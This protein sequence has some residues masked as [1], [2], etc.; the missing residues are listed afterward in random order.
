M[1]VR[2]NISA[3]EVSGADTLVTPEA[4]A[5]V[6]MLH[7][8]FD[9][10]R[11]ELLAEREARQARFD[12]GERPAFLDATRALREADWT[13]APIPDDLLDRRVEIT[14][15]PTRKMV[16]NAL[17]SGATHFMADFEDSTAPTWAN[18]VEGQL[19]LREAV[20][21]TLT[22]DDPARGKHYALA[23]ERAVLLVRPR[24]WH[25]DEAHATVDGAPVS[26]S[27]FDFGLYVFHNLAALR[28]RGTSAYFYL[29]KLEHHEE[30][31]LWD[32]VFAC[33]EEALAVPIGTL[34][35]TVLVETLPAAFQ[36][37]E[38]LHALRN[39]VVGLNCGRWDYIFSTIKTLRAHGDALLPDRSQVGMTAPFMDAYSRLVI[40]TCHKRGCHAMGGMAAQ[41]PLRHDPEANAT[42]LEKVRRDKEREVRNG[43]DGT[44]VAH[45]GLVGLAR[46]IFDE[47]MPGA[48]QLHRLSTDL[49]TEAD[50]LC[51]PE[52]T[53]TLDGLRHSIQVGVRYLE[54]WLRGSGCVPLFG[55]MEDTATAEICRAQVWQWIHLGASLSDGTPVTAEA[56]G[57]WLDEELAVL[58][59]E[60]GA[61][62]P[63]RRFRQAGELFR[64][65]STSAELTP[66][67]TSSAYPILL[68]S[69]AC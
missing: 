27:L 69:E 51:L 22:F 11:R 50:L 24:A 38:I 31:A 39:H 53:R 10:R 66:F 29:P 40:Q 43:H 57:T 34:K 45:P 5:F 17:N 1:T 56:F 25:L 23:D 14:G 54:A 15:P 13:V 7:D 20:R 41:I 8:R 64:A 4:N 18:V 2:M 60:P 35:A 68:E 67:L 36:L 19:A 9:A 16:I 47:H 3:P 26:A 63:E 58:R 42:A 49:V 55:L 61:D 6:G 62:A 21:G 37:H 30:A 12:A 32:D 48:N 46:E 52:G 28:E 65:L 59:D 33:A 44:W